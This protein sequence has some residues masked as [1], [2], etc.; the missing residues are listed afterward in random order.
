MINIQSGLVL[1]VRE[2]IAGADK[3]DI[4]VYQISSPEKWFSLGTW[5]DPSWTSCSPETLL[6]SIGSLVVSSASPLFR[7]PYFWPVPGHQRLSEN[8]S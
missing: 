1:E 8:R 7:K 3:A 5:G 2:G 4:I 6:Q